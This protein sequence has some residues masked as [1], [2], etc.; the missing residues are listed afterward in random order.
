[1]NR[2]YLY[3]DGFFETIRILNGTIP[4]LF[5]HLQ[6]ISEALDIY[7]FRTSFD[8]TE[9]FIFGIA[10]SY[11]PN[12]SLRINFFRDGGGKYLPDS[13]E[14]AIDHSFEKHSHTFF[15]P[16]SLDLGLDLQKAPV[17]KGTF[18][19]YSETK[20]IVPWMTVKSMSSVYYVLAAKYK[21]AKQVDYLFLQNTHG[22]ICEELNS[23]IL[24]QQG[25]HFFIPSLDSGGVNGA[26][27]RYLLSNYGFA[28]TEKNLTMQDIEAA[29]SIYVC[30]A[31]TG[32]TRI[33]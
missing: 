6:R 10:Q 29:E 26:T 2:G 22:S 31:T 32:V 27:Q 11:S 14:V 5:N 17:Q 18:T 8:I 16:T 7:S 12:G 23:T 33:K 20:P 25:E 24:I 28:V 30:K 15:L 3:G 21:Q 13:D 19:L 1:M 9:D 4:L